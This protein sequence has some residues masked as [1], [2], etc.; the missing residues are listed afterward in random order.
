MRHYRS[1]LGGYGSFFAGAFVAA[2][3]GCGL[4][5]EEI[6]NHVGPRA[7]S[8]PANVGGAS[9]APGPVGETPVCGPE[10]VV[11]VQSPGV[12]LIS[13]FEDG[14][15][16]LLPKPGRAGGWF[17]FS[18]ATPN[19]RIQPAPGVAPVPS[20][21]IPTGARCLMGNSSFALHVRGGGFHDWGAGFGSDLGFVVPAPGTMGQ[22]ERRGVDASG[23]TAI[24]FWAR[25]GNTPGSV[26][27]IRFNLKDVQTDPDGGI[28]S[29]AMPTGASACHDDF[30]TSVALSPQWRKVVLP[31]ASMKQQG[32]GA[33]YDRLRTDALLAIQV[34][35][36]KG[37][38]FDVWVDDV[39][40]VK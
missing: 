20:E 28:C 27:A 10:D 12:D 33:K 37:S 23:Y 16:G 26:G 13:D 29:A 14:H 11:T 5:L 9:G 17:T 4:P 25:Q 24:A 38:T 6:V 18:D 39:H 36:P 7:G 31:F 40:F 15:A 21:E 22:G 19:G 30:G 34:I 3:A 32:F 1:G 8:G 2:M 35:F